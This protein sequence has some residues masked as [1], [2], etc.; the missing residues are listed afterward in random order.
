MELINALR[1]YNSCLR[2]DI[3]L[4]SA[5]ALSCPELLLYCPHALKPYNSQTLTSIILLMMIMS[6][7]GQNRGCQ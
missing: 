7:R 1:Q 2:P 5:H 3:H 4:P 6:D